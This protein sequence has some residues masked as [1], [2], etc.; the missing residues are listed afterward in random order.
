MNWVKW[1][2]HRVCGPYTLH[3]VYVQDL[4]DDL[5]APVPAA[6]A[7]RLERITDNAVLW[8]H[9][10]PDIRTLR[11]YWAAREAHGFA[12]WMDGELAAACWVWSGD[13]YRR[14]NL[15]PLQEDEAKLVELATAAAWRGRGLATLVIQYAAVE[16]RA[17]GFRR[18]YSLIWHSNEA[19]LTSFRKA[20][21]RQCAFVTI[22]YPFGLPWKLRFVYRNRAV[23]NPAHAPAG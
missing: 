21:W 20:G 18:M 22:I 8:D 13:Q 17:A 7:C 14:R 23:P 11:A 2:A 15:W 19:S 3:R 1:L 12:A 4:T 16:M 9:P 10:D 5:V 6:R